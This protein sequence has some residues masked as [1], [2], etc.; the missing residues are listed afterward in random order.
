MFCSPGLSD[1]P[2][3]DST[4]EFGVPSLVS[5]RSCNDGGF[6]GLDVGMSVK[7]ALVYCPNSVWRVMCVRARVQRRGNQSE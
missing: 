3:T 6:L 2:V 4:V 5:S 7:V 1:W